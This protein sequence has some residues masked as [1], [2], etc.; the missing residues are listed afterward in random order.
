MWS[1]ARSARAQ[2]EEVGLTP[3][4]VTNDEPSTTYRLATSW[5]RFQ[6]SSTLVARVVAHPGR[7]QQVPAGVAHQPV[8]LDLVGARLEQR[9]GRLLDVEVEHAG[10]SSRETAYWISGAGMPSASR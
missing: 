5:V 9:L 8:D 1:A 4:E 7:A 6:R 3:A 10:A 2:I